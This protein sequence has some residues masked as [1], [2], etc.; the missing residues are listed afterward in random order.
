MSADGLPP[1][2]CDKC[3][4]REV[5]VVDVRRITATTDEHRYSCAACGALVV[6][7]VLGEPDEVDA[8]GAELGGHQVA[9]DLEGRS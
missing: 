8:R 4:A 3:G 6:T 5:P 9:V 1:V 7:V 2:P